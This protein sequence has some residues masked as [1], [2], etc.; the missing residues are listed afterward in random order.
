MP[1]W[2]AG[3]AIALPRPFPL[4]QVVGSSSD[5]KLLARTS[6]QSSLR[7]PVT[8]L[9]STGCGGAACI[10]RVCCRGCAA[11]LAPAGMSRV[12]MPGGLSGPA[13]GHSA[14]SCGLPPPHLSASP[15]NH[16]PAGWLCRRSQ[17][18]GRVARR[19][20][21]GGGRQGR[22]A[23]SV[24]LPQRRADGGV[25]ELLWRPAVLLL[26]PRWALCGGGGRGRHARTVWPDR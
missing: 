18:G 15:A 5:T 9:Q 16:P 11:G 19:A 17:R 21:R 7:P 12:P 6:S 13:G 10:G 2:P 8:Q 23:A 24:C 25:Q 3:T 22:R 4:L 26:E 20:P 14:H 1:C